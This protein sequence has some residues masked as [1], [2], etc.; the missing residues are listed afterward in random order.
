[1]NLPRSLQALYLLSL[2]AI[3]TMVATG[4]DPLQLA[5]QDLPGVVA[6]EDEIEA[7]SPLGAGTLN[8]SDDVPIDEWEGVTVDEEGSVTAV[9]LE[10][11]Q[12]TGPIP[13]SLGNLENLERLVLADNQLTGSIPETFTNLTNLKYLDLSHNQLTGAVPGNSVT[14]GRKQ[15]SSNQTFGFPST[16]PNLDHLDLSHNQFTGPLPQLGDSLTFVDL[17]FNRYTGSIPAAIGNITG[18]EKLVLSHNQLIG[19]IPAELGKLRPLLWLLLDENQ[20]AGQIPDELGDL[21]RLQSLS[22][23]VDRFCV[24]E[25]LAKVLIFSHVAICDETVEPMADPASINLQVPSWL[26]GFWMGQATSVPPSVP[27][28]LMVQLTATPRNLVFVGLNDD[29]S[30]QQLDIALEIAIYNSPYMVTAS[31][32]LYELVAGPASDQ[33]RLE[34]MPAASAS[35]VC[36]FDFE[37]Q[38]MT[39]VLHKN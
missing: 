1:M 3:V 23:D 24:S 11:R 30:S 21:T 33:L 12:L 37:V 15:A 28:V 27:P 18:L 26:Q 22:L 32:T 14:N 38:V 5:A 13:A 10:G 25:E 2:V 4:C 35:V 9:E 36:E 29:G 7:L 16:N 34:C 19:P 39:L 31:A 8:W 17:S 20:L 6:S